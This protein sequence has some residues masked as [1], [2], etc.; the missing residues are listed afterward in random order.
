[1]IRSNNVQEFEDLFKKEMAEIART[2]MKSV[3]PYLG[4]KSQTSQLFSGT[5]EGKKPQHLGYE[6][7]KNLDQFELLTEIVKHER[8]NFLERISQ[9]NLFPI[10]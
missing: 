8:V 3:Q 4:G 9:K 2:T 7:K 5:G 1:M 6:N 10:T